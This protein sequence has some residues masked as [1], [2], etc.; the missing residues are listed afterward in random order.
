M[1]FILDNAY[2]ITDN[3]I[4]AIIIL[5]IIVNIL[6]LPLH[7]FAEKLQTIERNVQKKLRPKT[8]E[9]SAFFQGAERFMMM[10]T[11]YR[12]AKYHPIY[13][14]RTSL[15]F[16]IQVPFFLAAYLLL[17]NYEPFKGVSVLW[18]S[19]LSLADG[20][21]FGVNIMPIVMTLVNLASGFIYTKNLTKNEKIQTW[22]IA[23]LFLVLLYQ[24]PVALVLYWTLNNVFFLFKNI[25][26]HHFSKS[27]DLLP[28][29][30]QSF[31]I[32]ARGFWKENLIN[33]SLFSPRY[34]LKDVLT[35]GTL[36]TFLI[37]LIVDRFV[38]NNVL[39]QYSAFHTTINNFVIGVIFLLLIALSIKKLPINIRFFFRYLGHQIAALKSLFDWR[40]IYPLV[41]VILFSIFLRKIKEYSDLSRVLD[42]THTDVSAAITWA[43]LIL[44]CLCGLALKT[45]YHQFDKQKKKYLTNAT[46]TSVL[47]LVIV[48]LLISWFTNSYLITEPIYIKE[49]LTG[50]LCV[51]LL[52]LHYDNIR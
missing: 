23:I 48:T 46:I 36:K 32:K 19:D 28:Q 51:L 40:W 34:D 7:H 17:L 39:Q 4:I 25:A 37:L 22:V 5:S 2:H 14:I 50:V 21:I 38:H 31:F 1:V 10:H 49:G 16:L 45:F 47:A 35:S 30:E 9:I 11:L 29:P 27:T 20:L 6:L 42:K 24:S 3:Y 44:I 12:Q 15:G 13:A 18:F 52:F 8:E 26:Y 33:G 41:W 43:I